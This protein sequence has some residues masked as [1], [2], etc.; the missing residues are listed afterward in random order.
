M[1][2]RPI[3]NLPQSGDYFQTFNTISSQAQSGDYYQTFSAFE[4]LL[5]RR[6]ADSVAV[7]LDGR[8]SS[9]PITSYSEL[10]RMINR[11]TFTRPLSKVNEQ[12]KNMLVRLF[13]SWLL[14]AY[15]VMFSGP[16]PQ[17]SAWMN[18]WVTLWTTQWLMGKSTLYDLELIGGTVGKDQ[19]LLVDKC[20]F[21][22]ETG[23]VRTCLNACKVPTQRFFL[24]EMGLPV[25]LRPNMTDLSCRFE[26]G[27]MPVPLDQDDI[28]RSPCLAMCT[29][30]EKHSEREQEKACW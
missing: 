14:P 30:R 25:T 7:E 26:F 18:S 23:C 13:P 19:G 4:K 11:M 15:K 10:M 28:S 3:V 9:E 1:Q 5:F 21:L 29:Q 2:L 17:F 8:A 16:F 27:I 20:R 6:F 12:G 22:E 24:E